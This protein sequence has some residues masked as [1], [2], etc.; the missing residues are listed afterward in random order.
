MPH[1]Q[2][3]NTGALFRNENKTKDTSPDYSGTCTIAGVE[4]FFDSWIKTS[5]SGRKWMSFSFKA[6]KQ[7]KGTGKPVRGGRVVDDDSDVPF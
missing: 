4:M 6:K 3:D 7:D 2:R 1:N 5:E